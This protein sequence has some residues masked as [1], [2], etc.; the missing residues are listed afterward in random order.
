VKAQPKHRPIDRSGLIQALAA[1]KG[2]RGAPSD[3][4]RPPVTPAPGAKR[5]P[6]PG[7][8]DLDGRQVPGLPGPRD[9]EEEPAA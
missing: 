9:D 6:L 7:Q 4:D 3:D 8:L 1:L 2:R 5:K